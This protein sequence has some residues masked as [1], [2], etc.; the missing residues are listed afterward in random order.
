MTPIVLAI[1]GGSGAIYAIRLMQQLVLADQVLE[2][3]ISPSGRSVMMQELGGAFCKSETWDDIELTKKTMLG[4]R[5]DQQFADIDSSRWGADD[6]ASRYDQ[7]HLNGYDDYFS[8]VASGSAKTRGMII[9]PCSGATMSGV[10][11]AA[12]NNLIQRAA[13]VHLKER[14]PL[15][16]VP[17]E[18]PLSTL[19]L[20]N[21]LRVAQAGATILPAMPGWYHGVRDL[22][23]LVDF[24]VARILDHLHIDHQLIK[25]WA[26]NED[27]EAST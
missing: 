16:C 20:E 7:V 1:T 5:I 12:G 17:R 26:E 3:I 22:L 27:T 23:D 21:M 25:R 14:R 19:Q 6:A 15:I 18:T 10:A 4:Y 2:I 11:H 13:D 9:C 8:K 24:I